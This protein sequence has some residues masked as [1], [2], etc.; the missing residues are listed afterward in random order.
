M[1]RVASTVPAR[2]WSER[3]FIYFDESK[4]LPH[5]PAI[6][7]NHMQR[8]FRAYPKIY[9]AC[10]RQHVRDDVN[11]R[12]LTAHKASILDHLDPQHP[13]I[14]SEMARHLSVTESTMSLQISRLE[15]LGYVRRFRDS[16]DSRRIGVRLT[17]I[18][19]RIRE[20]NSVLDPDLARQMLSLLSGDER[21]T[22]LHGLELLGEAAERLM[23]KRQLR[24]RKAAR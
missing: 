24:R 18:G 10:H 6:V 12:T 16:A 9:L 5:A 17:S 4:H 19:L 8:L 7:S 13:Q 15:E 22:A 2:E 11:G 21:E 1:Q 3:A 20:Q 14:I 23:Q